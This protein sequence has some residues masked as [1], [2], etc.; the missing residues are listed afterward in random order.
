MSRMAAVTRMPSRVRNGL[1]LISTGNSLPS[2]RRPNSSRPDPIGR[3]C[4]LAKKALR[5]RG[6]LAGLWID[7][8]CPSLT[9][10]V[11]TLAIRQKALQRCGGQGPHKGLRV[12]DMESVR[13]EQIHGLAEEFRA[14]IAKHFF[15][16]GV[17]DL[18]SAVFV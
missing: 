17:H 15:Q 5:W 11:G 13:D 18:N 9:R 6:W 3:T 4:G 8:E 16:L 10:L 14:R 12:A 2:L 7:E 1:K